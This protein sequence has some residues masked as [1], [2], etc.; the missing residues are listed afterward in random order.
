MK[1][2]PYC[3]PASQDSINTGMRV[4]FLT[5]LL[6]ACQAESWAAVFPRSPNLD[7]LEKRLEHARKLLKEAPLV[8]GHNDLPLS[9]RHL[10]E[11]RLQDF[12]FDRNLSAIEPFASE[13][14]RTDLV[15]LRAGGVGGQFWSLFTPC[16][17]QFKNAV[18][19]V[20]EQSDVVTRLVERYPDHLQ[21]VTTADGIMSAHAQGKIASLMGVE[22]GHN[23]D[24]S[25]AVLRTLYRVG[26]RY[27]TLTHTCNTP[28]ADSSN[29]E[30]EKGKQVLES[31]GLSRFG[32]TVVKEMNRLGM[33]VDLSHVATPTMLDALRVTRAPVIF[34]HSSARALCNDSRNVP[35]DVLLKVRDNGG[36][37][38]VTF[39][40]RF[41]SCGPT[42][43]LQHVVDHI[44]HI[45]DVAG[46]DHVGLGGD[47][48][49][50]PVLPEGLED[51]SKYPYLFAELLKDSS[52]TEEDLKKLA[53]LNLVRVFRQVEQVR[54]QLAAES[55]W[56]DRLAGEIAAKHETCAPPFR[57]GR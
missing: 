25:L 47:Y 18:S 43:T 1:K 39:V 57:K 37:V 4:G 38:M 34:S 51:T 2:N 36:L 3:F 48:N 6:V 32:E 21:L 13:S 15:K 16:W 27:L 44:N 52:W 17:S 23:I 40:A 33:L 5:L 50:T 45:R 31:G 9:I 30:L 55:P 56:E 53:G 8:D 19:L 42:A 49:G 26:V 20:L 7:T 11:N 35:D 14:P 24:S 54:D 22:G 12:S 10:L 28:W 46:V 41:L 29:A